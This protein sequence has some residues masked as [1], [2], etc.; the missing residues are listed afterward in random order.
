MKGRNRENIHIRISHVAV[1]LYVPDENDRR[2]PFCG[3]PYAFARVY[4]RP[5]VIFVCLNNCR[6]IQ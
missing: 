2:Y 3:Q 5:D 6:M 4:I 1:Y